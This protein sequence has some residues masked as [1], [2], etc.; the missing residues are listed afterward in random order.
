MRILDKNGNPFTWDKNPQT[1]QFGTVFLNKEYEQHP[2]FGITPDKIKQIFLLAERGILY[3]QCD[4]ASDIIELD[5]HI[6]SE[7]QKRCRAILQLKWSITPPHA[8]S[9]KERKA[10]AIVNDIISSIDDLEDLFLQMMSAVLYGY[11]CLEIA[12]QENETGWKLIGGVWK[13]KFQFRP[14]R[15]FCTKYDAQD[16]LFLRDSMAEMGAA[17]LIPYG[18]IKHIHKNVSGYIPRGGLIRAIAFPFLFKNY[19]LRDLAQ[20]LETYGQPI[21]IGKYGAGATESDRLNLFEAIKNIGRNAGGI[22]PDD[23]SLEFHEIA[24]AGADNFDLMIR[25]MDDYISKLFLG[26]TLTSGTQ[27]N[28]G[29]YALG[30]VHNSVRYELLISDAKQIATTLTRDLVYPLQY[31]N[32]DVIDPDR[33]CRFEFS[34]ENVQDDKLLIETVTALHSILPIPAA[35]AYQKFGIPEPSENEKTLGNAAQPTTA[36]QP[37]QAKP[38]YKP[39]TAPAISASSD[40]DELD[41]LAVKATDG[42]TK[43]LAKMLDPFLSVI[44]SAE[45]Y[46]ALK[47][48]LTVEFANDIDDSDFVES[49]ENAIG[50]SYVYGLAMPKKLI[51]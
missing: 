4:L 34:L 17:E 3:P 30:E 48:S 20:M 33:S 35:W 49:L 9:R 1:N 41:R 18:W 38:Q 14:Q 51:K 11:A 13:P 32:T 28:V 27:K 42:A 46:D 15:M 5:P 24:K 7:Y 39:F 2:A 6:H 10:A 23:M 45:D 44:D 31:L 19:T 12:N 37:L 43:G 40:G 47:K 8:A 16:N 29:S 26:G 22:I 50:T 21:K 25:L 36:P